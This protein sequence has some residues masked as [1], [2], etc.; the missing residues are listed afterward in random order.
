MA[1][2]HGW[3]STIGLGEEST[4]GTAVTPTRFFEFTS[5]GF[6]TEPARM[7][8]RAIRA[9]SVQKTAKTG[10]RVIAGDLSGELPT[11]G[12]GLFLKHLLGAPAISQPDDSGAPT[13]YDQTFTPG[14]V[15]GLGLTVQKVIDGVPFTYSGCKVQQ[16][17]LAARV[18][19]LCTFTA[20][21]VGQ[22]STTETAAASPSYPSG[23][24]C[25]TFLGGFLSTETSPSTD[26]NSINPNNGFVQGS[27]DYGSRGDSGSDN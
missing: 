23:L 5:E 21:L 13:V 9:Q 17:Q 16:M 6:T 11:V 7:E 14:D 22:D 20:S 27:V 26:V 15:D 4:Y 10:Q 12:F 25:F 2:K 3:N 8:S 18:G 24:D 19:E 1:D